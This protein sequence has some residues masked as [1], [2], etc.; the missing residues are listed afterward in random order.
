MKMMLVVFAAV[1]ASLLLFALIGQTQKAGTVRAG[2]LTSADPRAGDAERPIFLKIDDTL[3]I[4]ANDRADGVAVLKKLTASMIDTGEFTVC[5]VQHLGEHGWLLN[6]KSISLPDKSEQPCSEPVIAEEKAWYKPLVNRE[7]R[8]AAKN[9]EEQ[10]KLAR[11]T[12]ETNRSNALDQIS[13]A[14][15]TSE[16]ANSACTAFYDALASSSLVN[17]A[18][19]TVFLSDAVDTCVGSVSNLPAPQ[20]NAKILLIMLPSRYDQGKGAS[21]FEAFKA[22]KSVLQSVAPWLRVESPSNANFDGLVP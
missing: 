12:Y 14:I 10:Q 1:F 22:R 7:E 15:T 17:R 2:K 16:Q 6:E 3:S 21:A 19:L 11:Q 18:S 9:C 5:K 13:A 4:S 8:K 20:S